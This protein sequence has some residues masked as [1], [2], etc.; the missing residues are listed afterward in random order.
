[1]ANHPHV[2]IGSLTSRSDERIAAADLV[3]SLG[4]ANELWVEKFNLGKLVRSSEVV[5]I[6][7]PHTLAMKVAGELYEREKIVIDLSADFR[8]SRA[9]VYERWYGER[10]KRRDLL[11]VAVYGLPEVYRDRLKGTNFIANPGCYPTGVLLVRYPL[12]WEDLIR[13]DSILVDS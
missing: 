13:L 8:L 4:K 11:K 6:T 10:H 7:L 9:D 2:K 3:P 12:V 5:F 1:L